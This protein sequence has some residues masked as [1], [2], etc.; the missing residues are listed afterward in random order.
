MLTFVAA[1]VLVLLA[2]GVYVVRLV[3]ADR[4]LARG[5]SALNE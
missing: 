1:Y 3:V 4:R 5:Q 2:V